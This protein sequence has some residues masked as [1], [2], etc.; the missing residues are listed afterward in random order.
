MSGT[1]TP[2][3]HSLAASCITPAISVK[4]SFI[5]LKTHKALKQKKLSK[6]S[7]I[8]SQC[9]HEATPL[10]QLLRLFCSGHNYNISLLDDVCKSPRRCQGS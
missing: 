3:I 9:W 10:A 5:C 2:A 6:H 7:D 4:W 8:C 1:T